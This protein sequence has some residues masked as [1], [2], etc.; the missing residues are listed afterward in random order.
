MSTGPVVMFL[1]AGRCGTQWLAAGL[2]E[3]YPALAVEHEPIGA[4]YRP[5]RFFRRYDD[6]EAI[7]AVREVRRHLAWVQSLPRYVETG[8]PLFA[9]LP[10]LAERIGGRLRVVHL[11]RHPVP[12]ALSHLAHNSYAGSARDDSYTRNATLAPS[13]PG[14]FQ[15]HYASRWETLSAY[16]RCLFWWTEVNLFAL[17]FPARYPDVAFTRVASERLLAG[18][19]GTL[20]DLLAFMDLPWVDSWLDHPGRVVDCWHHHTDRSLDP[21]QALRHQATMQ[22]AAVLGYAFSGL[23]LEA[24]E[25]RYRGIPDAGLERT[26]VAPDPPAVGI[27]PRPRFR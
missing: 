7:L 14:V 24:L 4:D 21:L 12:S 25:A 2:R 6:P 15:A 23:D 18:D 10:L 17:E 13:D 8:W 20:E 9:A 27:Q 5:R 1:S 22:V 16:E 19:R 26:P 3:R 11:T